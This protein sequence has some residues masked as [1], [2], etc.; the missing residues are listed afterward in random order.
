MIKQRIKYRSLVAKPYCA[1]LACIQAVMNRHGLNGYSQEDLGFEMGLV[2]PV[3]DYL[4]F[5]K[6]HISVEL[7]PSGYGARIHLTKYDPNKFFKEHKIP[8]VAKLHL[9]W[10]IANLPEFVAVQHELDRDVMAIYDEAVFNG[11]GESKGCAAL[12]EGVTY[13]Q[14]AVIGPTK[15]GFKRR[16]VKLENLLNAVETREEHGG[17]F[18]LFREI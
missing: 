7:P 14:A 4:M 1:E 12:I 18:W 8:L 2:V 9:P 15:S 11:N 13:E 16:K 17:G 3:E 10:E 5:N 6:I